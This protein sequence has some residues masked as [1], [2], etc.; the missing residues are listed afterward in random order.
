[1]ERRQI[2]E[3]I[4]AAGVVGAGG[5]GF[6]THV[7]VDARVDTVIANGAECEPL[8]RVDKLLMAA[9]PQLVVR[10]LQ[11]VMQACGARRGVLALKAK[12]GDSIAALEGVLRGRGLQEQIELYLLDDFYPAGDEFVLVRQ[13]TGRVIPEFGLPLQVGVVVSNVT[14]LAD[15]ARAVDEGRPVSERVVAVLGEVRRQ[16][17]FTVP[18]GTPLELL[19]EAAGG[20]GV[21]GAQLLEGGPMMGRL[22]R[23]RDVVTK[24]TSLLLV[25]PEQHP[26]VQ[27]RLRSPERQ[28][29]LTR[30]ACLKCMLCTEICPRNLLGHGLY[31]DRLMRNLAAGVSEDIDAFT[32]AW[33]CSECGLCAVYGC[34]MGLD[35]CAMNRLLKQKLAAAG[36]D[37]PP[38]RQRPERREGPLRQVPGRRLLARLAVRDYDVAVA[39]QPFT[40]SLSRLVLPLRQHAGAAAVPV[41]EPGQEVAAGALLGEIPPDRLGA[42][43]HSPR[44]GRV[45]AVDGNMVT[46]EVE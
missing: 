34:V 41:V 12:A 39:R 32:G 33:L 43:V 15:V 18:L 42:R 28:L 4:R 19:V 24:T 44:A 35:P 25:L 38:P 6:P 30:S 40:P 26:V 1:M 20:A 46:L 21:E 45:L 13:V 7:K 8:A 11:L 22:A 10:G 31:P 2:I 36:L 14:T 9:E 29:Q 3:R 17:A 37:R 27:R 16:A 23:S 5:G